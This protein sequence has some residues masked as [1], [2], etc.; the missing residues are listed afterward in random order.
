MKSQEKKIIKRS[1]NFLYKLH[2]QVPSNFSS[3]PGCYNVLYTTGSFDL[4][5]L[6]LIGQFILSVIINKRWVSDLSQVYHSASQLFK[7]A[8][9]TVRIADNALHGLFKSRDVQCYHYMDFTDMEE[10]KRQNRNP[11]HIQFGPVNGLKVDIN[12]YTY[13]VLKAV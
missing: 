7:V 5:F 12:F 4:I 11:D 10:K 8:L 6:I 2:D 9:A 13:A 1:L 3:N